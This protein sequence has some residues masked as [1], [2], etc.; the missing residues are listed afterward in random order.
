MLAL[1]QAK[2]DIGSLVCDT[3]FQMLRGCAQILESALGSAGIL[4]DHVPGHAGDPFNEICD[5][6]AKQEGQKG[7]F[8]PR[9]QLHLATWRRL[10]PYLWILFGKTNGVPT[11]QGTGFN[12]Q[13]PDLPPAV[14]PD[15]RSTRRSS[16][17]LI[18]F[19]ISIATGNVQSLGL[20]TQG[21]TGK[22]QY[23]RT[24]FAALKLNFIGLQETRSPEGLAHKYGILRL[25]SGSDNGQAGVEL[26]C[27]LQQPIATATQKQV[28][29][30]RQHFLVVHRDPRRLLV[31]IQHPLWEAW[32]LVAYAPHSGLQ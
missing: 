17:K 7:F 13:P 18:N 6:I 23:L 22:L 21:F 19:A 20:G 9:P 29:L 24:Q 30:Q 3:S 4:F 8:L 1:Q 14:V 25:S 12:V 32:I 10:I 5:Q 26:W 11:F 15:R 31:R 2:G 28:F 27:N 16:R